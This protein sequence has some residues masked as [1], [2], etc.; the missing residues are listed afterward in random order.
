[1]NKGR[2]NLTL[3]NKRRNNIAPLKQLEKKQERKKNAEQRER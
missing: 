2:E 3:I 1:M